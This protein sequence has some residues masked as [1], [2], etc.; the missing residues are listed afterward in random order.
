[1]ADT[2]GGRD[3][4]AALIQAAGKRFAPP[5]SDYQRVRAA[6]HAS[7]RAMVRRR[8]RRRWA[9]ALAASVILALAGVG[10]WRG[11]E[12][13]E[14][15]MVATLNMTH[16]AL[17]A[18]D[19][20]G[21]EWR[22]VP[23]AHTSMPAGTRLRTVAAAGAA[24]HLDAGSSL[25]MDEN[26]D[27][28]LQPEN[29]VELLAGRVYVDTERTDGDDA[30]EIVTAFGT[31]RDR[32]TQFEVRATHTGLRVRT[33]E[34]SVTLVQANTTRVI[35]CAL[36]EELHIDASGRVERGTISPFDAEWSWAEALSEPPP[37]EQLPL[38]QFLEWV[39]H[40][41]GRRVKYATP[42]T[43]ARVR[44][45]VLN[46]PTPNVPPVRALALT[47]ATTDIDYVLL[48]DGS[49]LLRARQTH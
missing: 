7:W 29:R 5:Q 12:T 3:S 2:P 30:V 33:R 27:L 23:D 37:G 47:L 1:M 26:T 21:A 20:S 17:F 41:T 40:E 16:G 38:L 42:E 36:G 24:L 14:V 6:S 11:L 48:E 46:G 18:S 43:E 10:L 15:A 9:F 49:I 34:G 45:V 13:R 31:L 35:E 28:L 44:R 39:S 8:A 32:G 19:A 22:W 25:R 4:L